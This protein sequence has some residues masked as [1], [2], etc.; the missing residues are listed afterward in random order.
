M[1]ISDRIADVMRRL[2]LTH[3]LIVLGPSTAATQ[4]PLNTNR[5]LLMVDAKVKL[6]PFTSTLNASTSKRHNSEYVGHGELGWSDAG[7]TNPVRRRKDWLVRRQPTL[8]HGNS[9]RTNQPCASEER[10]V[11][12]ETSDPDQW[13]LLAQKVSMRRMMSYASAGL[14]KAECQ[15]MPGLPSFTSKVTFSKI[16]SRRCAW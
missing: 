6:S 10:L 3:D 4:L 16:M 2:G 15:V 14:N 12:Q 11:G 8:T 13:E 5:S 7:P 9:C 1:Y